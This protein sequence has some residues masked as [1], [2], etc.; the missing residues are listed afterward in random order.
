MSS[1]IMKDAAEVES[2]LAFS[3]GWTRRTPNSGVVCIDWAC[4]GA[5]PHEL[6]QLEKRHPP[7]GLTRLT[8]VLHLG[9]GPKAKVEKNSLK[10]LCS[11]QLRPL[12]DSHSAVT[13]QWVWSMS[14]H[15]RQ[16]GGSSNEPAKPRTWS[17]KWQIDPKSNPD[18]TFS[19]REAS[20]EDQ[21]AREA[22]RPV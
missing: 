17:K 11:S 10:L 19:S 5:R 9:M 3:P 22:W 4:I 12:K 21:M 14:A 2:V 15:H 13:G 18:R 1:F 16:S 8:E 7:H 20:K 6:I